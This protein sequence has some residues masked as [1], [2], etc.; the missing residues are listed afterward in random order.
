[1]TYAKT[2]VALLAAV[3]A[4][5]LPGLTHQAGLTTDGRLGASGIANIVVLAAG[6]IQVF[7]A[8]NLPGWRYAKLIAAAVG[9]GGVVLISVLSDLQVS[10]QEWIQ[11]ALAV[12]GTLGVAAI[13]N[14]GTEDGVFVTGRHARALGAVDGGTRSW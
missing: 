1:M 3:L 13:P 4:A 12:L 8:G 7:N 14:A 10:P 5:V 2:L 11:V 9:A 6:T